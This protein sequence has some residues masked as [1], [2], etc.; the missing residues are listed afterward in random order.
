MKKAKWSWYPGGRGG[1]P[2]SVIPRGW[3]L[4]YDSEEVP[5]GWVPVSQLAEP[6]DPPQIPAACRVAV[7]YGEFWATEV[8]YVPFVSREAARAHLWDRVSERKISLNRSRVLVDGAPVAIIYA[9]P[10]RWYDCPAGVADLPNSIVREIRDNYYP[11]G[12]QV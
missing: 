7:K 5:G 3:T 12:G 10:V 8:A 6:G 4:Y 2:G 11:G 9:D 1:R